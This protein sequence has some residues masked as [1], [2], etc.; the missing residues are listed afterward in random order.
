METGLA[1]LYRQALTAS[2]VARPS[3][4]GRPSRIREVT[5]SSRIW[6]HN[7]LRLL[8]RTRPENTSQLAVPDL[9]QIKLTSGANSSTN[10][11]GEQPCSCLVRSALFVLYGL[12]RTYEQEVAKA[13]PAE[14]FAFRGLNFW[15]PLN[16]SWGESDGQRCFF[17]SIEP[18]PASQT[19][20]RHASPPLDRRLIMASRLSDTLAD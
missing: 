7:V 8:S 1:G 14:C 6:R 19:C 4:L 10:N 9:L 17:I 15:I 5:T 11:F 12:A 13:H 3:S 2:S 20:A 16:S 18:L